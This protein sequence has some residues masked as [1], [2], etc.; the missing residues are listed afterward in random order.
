MGQIMMTGFGF[1][2]KNFA[3]CNGQLL[4]I[5]QNQALF[6]LLGT[7][8][9]GN[10]IQTFGLPDLRS[11]TPAGGIQS[12]DGGWQPPQY[13]LGELAGQENVTLLTPQLPMHTHSVNVTS[14]AGT[15]APG[16]RN[17]GLTLAASNP[18]TATQ[19]GPPAALMPLGGAPLTPTGGSQ[20][21]PN[22]QPY[23]AINF[24]IAM[25]GIFPSRN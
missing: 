24:N 25:Y 18:D 23:Q 15:G 11:R 2:Q 12:Q 21:H 6:S 1:A 3:Q 14:V 22:I 8:Y 17:P 16:G 10:G 20:P 9:G 13:V 19:Y 4:G 5:A 7:T